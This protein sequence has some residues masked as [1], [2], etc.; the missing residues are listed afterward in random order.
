MTHLVSMPKSRP[1][2]VEQETIGQLELSIDIRGLTGLEKHTIDSSEE[3]K[4]PLSGAGVSRDNERSREKGED[5]D[6][7]HAG[8]EGRGDEV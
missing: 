2:T 5:L 8:E 4:G 6:D 7:E 1:A 3:R